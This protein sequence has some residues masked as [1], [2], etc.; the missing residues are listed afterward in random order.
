M[1][2]L[3]IGTI[4]IAMVIYQII[5]YTN[6]LSKEEKSERKKRK[7]ELKAT[8]AITLPHFYGLPVAEGTLCNL[9]LCE[10]KIVFESKGATFNLYKDKIIDVSDKSEE[11]ISK[12]YVSSIGGAV[13]G[14]L[15]FGPLGAMIG[16]RTKEKVDKEERFFLIFTYKEKNENKYISFLVNRDRTG[17]Y[18]FIA[19]FQN[20]YN[21]KEFNL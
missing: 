15:L 18:D 12:S 4:F 14:A 16:G 11:E 6:P 1:F 20:N 8:K 13:G 21:K 10:D 2:W 3:I 17:I 19:D 5:T 7:E 9:Y